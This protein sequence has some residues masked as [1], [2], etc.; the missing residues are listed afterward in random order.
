MACPSLYLHQI[1]QSM[2]QSMIKIHTERGR[3]FFPQKIIR[4]KELNSLMENN[5]PPTANKATD[6]THPQILRSLANKT[7][8]LFRLLL[9]ISTYLT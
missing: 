4:K 5:I 2:Q 6:N 3:Y 7:V 9:T 8:R 1:F